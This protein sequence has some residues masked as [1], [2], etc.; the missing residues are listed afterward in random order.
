VEAAARLMHVPED[1]F[2]LNIQRY[3]NTSAAS[4]PVALVEAIE[5]GRC[6]PG[7]TLALVAFGA[8]LTWASAVMHLGGP[9]ESVS[10]SLADELL[11]LA[12][13]KYYARRAAGAVQGAATDL[14]MAVNDRLHF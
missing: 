14:V 1:R 7:D 8:G 10:V 11:L 3:G 6:K 9:D 12:R 5:E 2:Y 4:V 13:A